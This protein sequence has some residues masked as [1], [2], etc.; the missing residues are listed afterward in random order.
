M[1]NIPGFLRVVR[2][3]LEALFHLSELLCHFL[4]LNSTSLSI[5]AM[6]LYAYS[7][8]AVSKVCC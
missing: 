8:V 1:S 3:N 5:V 6:I 2:T 4:I 7:T